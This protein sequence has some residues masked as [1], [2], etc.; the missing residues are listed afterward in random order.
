M[1]RTASPEFM[2]RL[3]SLER[4]TR[5]LTRILVLT[6]VAAGAFVLMQLKASHLA[7]AQQNPP[8]VLEVRELRVMDSRGVERVR[9]AGN[10]PDPIVEGKRVPRQ[11][12]VA[13]VLIFD[14]D[15]DERGGYVTNQNGDAFLS[16]DAKSFQQTLFI[17]NRNGGANM[18]V[19]SGPNRNNNYV[20]VQAVPK[21]LI[22][23]RQDGK[24][25]VFA[26]GD[27]TQP[28]K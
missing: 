3:E 16:L 17:A 12:A 6:V 1:E 9:I 25:Q 22:E 2:A 7:Y 10:L 20:S 27:E 14:A 21:P 8:D 23:L 28:R 15:G 26:I 11:G 24:T 18:S 19:W 13:G 5:R 4:T